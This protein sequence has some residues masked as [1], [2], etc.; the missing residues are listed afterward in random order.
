[1]KNNMENNIKESLN[2]Y[3][4]PYDASAWTSLSSKLDQVMPVN[5]KPSNLKWY[6]GGAATVAAII[7]GTLLFKGTDTAKKNDLAQSSETTVSQSKDAT[8]NTNSADH[9][10]SQNNSSVSSN[11]TSNQESIDGKVTG[12]TDTEKSSITSSATNSNTTPNLNVAPNGNKIQNPNAGNNE[13]PRTADVSGKKVVFPTVSN[14]CLGEN[15]SINNMNDVELIIKGNEQRVAIAPNKKHTFKPGNDGKYTIQYISNGELVTGSS[16]MVLSAPKA[17][18][19]IIKNVNEPYKNGLPTIDLNAS[20]S[21]STY[22]WNLGNGTGTFSGKEIDAHYFD[23]G[24]YTISLTVTGS[25][26]CKAVETRSVSIDETYNLLAGNAI[27]TSSSNPERNSFMPDALSVRNVDFTMI[28]IDPSTGAI[29]FET[30]EATNRWTGV[31]KRTGQMVDAQRSF[32]WKVN[33]KNPE[34]GERSEYKG[35]VVRIEQ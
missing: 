19:D 30:S 11:E 21:G 4:M 10:T 34:K 5:P 17:D 8:Q 14:V 25:N 13:T 26:G 7:T 23:K 28:I 32:I 1:M 22:S 33:L 12:I 15:V 20:A 24:N 2:G 9:S 29:V 3:E 6:L 18:F 16:F 31:D 35:T 27:E